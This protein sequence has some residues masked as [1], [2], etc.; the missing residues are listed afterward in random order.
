MI[1][2]SRLKTSKVGFYMGNIFCDTLRYADDLCLL[3]PS[4]NATRI[5]LNIC[6]EYGNE[7][8]IK[9]NSTKSHIRLYNL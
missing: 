7:H 6:K 8:N 5:L 1:N 4:C 3:A 2:F 9:I